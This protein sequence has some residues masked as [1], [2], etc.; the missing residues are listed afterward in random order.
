MVHSHCATDEIEAMEYSGQVAMDNAKKLAKFLG[1][2][3]E[4]HV[5]GWRQYF[6]PGTA[7][8]AFINLNNLVFLGS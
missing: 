5:V 7:C 8:V 1:Q 4:F 6:L 2:H 3:E